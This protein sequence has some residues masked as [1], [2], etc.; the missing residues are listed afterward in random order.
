MTAE[1]M[2]L[3]CEHPQDVLAK[4][5]DWQARNAAA[6]VVVTAT[7]GGAVRAVGALMAVT[8]DGHA[9]GYISGG[10]IDADVIQ[11]ARDTLES[12]KPVSLR[13]GAGSPFVDLPLPCGGAI[14]VTIL[15]RAD[16]VALRTCH[17]A[18]AARQPARLVLPDAGI[19]AHY[20]PKLRLRIAGRGADPL[21]LARL[22]RASGIET[23]L[24]LRDGEDVTAATGEGFENVHTL[25]TPSDLPL[26]N[27]D[28]WTAFILMFHDGNWEGPLLTQAL[29]GPA[30]YVGAVGSRHTH[31]RRCEDLRSR[32]MSESEIARIH[33]PVGLI[34]SMRDASMLAV[35]TLAEIVAA[36]HQGAKAPFARTALVLLAAG[37]STRFEEGDK[38][39]ASYKGGPV[40]T[41]A[42][43]ALRNETVATRI[44]VTRPGAPSR[45]N[46]LN[47][48]GWQVLGNPQAD[49]GQASSLR[50][51]LK[52]IYRNKAVD[53]VMIL[54]AD[55]PDV[56]DAHLYKLQ[57]GVD[58]GASAAMTSSGDT[59]MPPAI[60]TR[61][62]FDQLMQVEGDKGAKGVFESLDTT[63]CVAL[64]PALAIDIDR[65]KDLETNGEVHHA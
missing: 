28:P 58:A 42:A 37:A 52:G 50:C 10:C 36:Y 38:L 17:D 46:L 56:P 4:W 7:E 5:L 60:F 30:F 55:M 27:D 51:A 8:R 59:L 45:E 31:A 6:L 24:Q 41:H 12:G 25:Q 44:A 32:G 61:A 43:A 15:P 20:A 47:T 40:L 26:A 64:D 14:E 13:Y 65:L 63:T 2:H 39:L 22:A 34:P 49:T 1:Q 62:T 23:T 53:R 54:L 9:A 48:A 29:N 21:A 18:L 19:D 3:Y 11:Q 57:R 33:G 35:S 16:E